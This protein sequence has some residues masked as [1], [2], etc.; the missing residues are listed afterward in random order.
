M[1]PFFFEG[2]RHA[3]FKTSKAKDFITPSNLSTVFHHSYN[4][5]HHQKSYGVFLDDDLS[6]LYENVKFKF[7]T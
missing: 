5:P 4:H 6:V 1:N 3:P 2:I 7:G